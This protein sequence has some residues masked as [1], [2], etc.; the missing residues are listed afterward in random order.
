[1][2]LIF[3]I[4]QNKRLIVFN[5]KKMLEAKMI[6]I[7]STNTKLL[8][9]IILATILLSQNA[10]ALKCKQR[11]VGFQSW[12]T[13]FKKEAAAQGISRRVISKALYGI[14]FA[15]D[16]I[17]RDRRQGVFSQSFKKFAGRM[18]SKNRLIKGRKLL[19]KYKSIFSKIEKKYGVPGPVLVAFWGL[20]TDFGAFLGDMPTLRSL[21]TLAYDCRR[22]ELF[23]D[24]LMAALKIIERGDLQKEQML[25]PWA[26]ELGQMQFLPTHY[27]E[28]GVDFDNDGQV[29]LIESISD[30]LASSANYMSHI[31]WKA[32]QPWIQ[33]V[34]LP[35]K[36]PWHEADIT[37]AKPRA[38]WV[39]LGVLN[40]ANKKIQSDDL[41]AS[42]ILPMGRFGPAFLVYDNFKNVY[43]EW[44]KSLLYSTTAAYFATRLSGA[45]PFNIYSKNIQHLS[46]RDIK[47]LQR[48]LA[49]RGYDVG[50]IDGIIGLGTRTAVK[51][52]QLKLGL[53]ADSYPTAELITKLE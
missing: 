7:Y 9:F 35:T 34:K 37:Q 19:K 42:L 27:I 5:D 49:K 51:D 40:K 15:P 38:A 33:E 41:K 46:I 10:F 18:V 13:G 43:L 22:P 14:T 23:H 11:N 2:I 24:Q 6:K 8:I 21:A 16:V 39:K 53:P 28:Y 26:G 25:G 17:K 48:L 32:N 12:L 1:M 30:V 45:K 3:A 52:M 47:K 36:F 44:N 50:K 31:G 29:N 20:E 4:K